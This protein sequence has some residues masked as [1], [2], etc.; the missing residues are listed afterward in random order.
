[1]S[2]L[3]KC[4]VWDLDNT[5]WD[6]ICLEGPVNVRTEVTAAIKEMDRRGILHSIASRGD[7]ETARSTLK[8]FGLEPIFL[9]P[10]INW[11][12]KSQNIVQI[13]KDL[14]L[15][16]DAIAFVDDDQFEREQVAFMLPDVLVIDAQGSAGLPGR[17]EFSPATVTAESLDRRRMYEA[18]LLRKGAE[19]GCV[20]REEFLHSC[21]MKLKIRPIQEGDLPRVLELMTRTHQ[22]NTTGRV[23]GEKDLEQ[24]M[25]DAERPVR[26]IIAELDDR[27]GGY[28]C[29]GTAMMRFGGDAARL[30]YLALS[31]RV[32]GRGIERAMIAWIAASAHQAGIRWLDA[33]YRDT[34]RNRMMRALY[35][36]EGMMEL[37]EVDEDGTHVFRAA[38]TE[39]PGGPAWV[40]VV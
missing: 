4:I 32:I 16:L 19:P 22:L 6:G 26:V 3:R 30:T 27:F 9:V 15:P 33:E 25:H 14:G 8:Q 13:S 28:G 37:P 36:M 35:L 2:P 23:L 10:R 7:E 1:M 38:C 5:L 34:G 20:S 39:I 24:V 29:I 31:C 40:E 21:R 11:L 18:E 12:P 17:P